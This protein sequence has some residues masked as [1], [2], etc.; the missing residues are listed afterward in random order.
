MAVCDEDYMRRALELAALAT[1]RTSPNPMVGAVIVNNGEVVGEG[2]HLRA[3]T[4]HAEIHALR[5]AGDRAR[6]ATLYVN[7]EPCSHYGRTPPC[8]EAV[9]AA[10]IRKV[11]LACQDPNPLVQGRGIAMLQQA[12]IEVETGLLQ[13]EARRL[14]EVFWKY[15]TTGRPFVVVKTAMTMDGKIA[16]RSGDSR[17]VTGAQARQMV[18]HFRDTYD[19]IMV[20]IGTVLADD[21]QLNTRLGEGIGRDPVR[22]IIDGYL[23]IP[24]DS[25]IAATSSHQRTIIFTSHSAHQEKIPALERAGIEVMVMDGFPDDL[26]MAS[27]M[28]L[29]GERHISS[30]LVEG[31]GTLN[32]TL[33]ENGLV[34]KVYWFVAPKIIGGREAPTPVEGVGIDRMADAVR[35]HDIR[36]DHFGDDILITGYVDGITE[37]LS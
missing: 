28:D 20:G 8:A 19:A 36:I 29:L 37:A 15:I 16:A 21:P 11:V 24:L 3:G 26:D 31:G 14:N 7:L 9:A 12:G 6:G 30:V 27:V 22:V 25:R 2:Y 33:F 1:G 5:Q 4:P 35:L 18:H 32:G 23:S 17:W 34:D 10:G 13:Q